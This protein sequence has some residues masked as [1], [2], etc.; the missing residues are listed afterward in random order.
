[1]RSYGPLW[2]ACDVRFPGAS[3]AAPH[4]RV[5]TGIRDRQSPLMLLINDPGPVGIGRQYEE[6]YLDFTA[7]NELLGI[8]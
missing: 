5:V 4:I 6:T 7:K 8:Q 1:M 2:V 3:R